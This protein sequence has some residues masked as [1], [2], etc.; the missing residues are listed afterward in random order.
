M[1]AGQTI[2]TGVISGVVGGII[3]VLLVWLIQRFVQMRRL[4]GAL[5]WR[6]PVY[7]SISDL[8]PLRG[9]PRSG[10]K[11][12]YHTRTQD[13]EISDSLIA[14]NHLLIIGDALCGKT[15]A[16]YEAVKKLRLSYRVLLVRDIGPS[17]A[18]GRL[19]WNPLKAL[20]KELVVL[21]DLHRLVALPDFPSLLCRLRERGA[22]LSAT[23]RSGTEG[24]LDI[25]IRAP[26]VYALFG[27]HVHIG[28][29]DRE[30]AQKVAQAAEIP[31]PRHF[32]GPIGSIFLNPDRVLAHL[33]SCTAGEQDILMS[34]AELH[35]AGAGS[36]QDGIPMELVGKACGLTSPAR[37]PKE[38][39]QLVESLAAKGL[40]RANR[41][42]LLC[43][44]TFLERVVAER[45]ELRRTQADIWSCL[46]G[47]PE[48]RQAV[49]LAAIAG[50]DNVRVAQQW[51]DRLLSSGIEPNAGLVAAAVARA[52]TFSLAK[53]WLETM[54][55]SGIK[56]N[57]IAY[58]SL[59]SKASTYDEAVKWFAQMR[60]AGIKPS[61]ISYTIVIERCNTYDE[62]VEWFTEMTNAGIRADVVAFT[63][64]IAM[65]ETLSEA[66]RWFREM[67]RA[68]IIPDVVVYSSLVAKAETYA[69][70]TEWLQKMREAGIAPNVVTYSS[71][72]DKCETY[73]SAIGL[74]K[75]MRNAG[76]T[77]DVVAYTA[78]ISK[79]KTCEDAARWLGEMQGAGIRPDAIAYGSVLVKCNSYDDAKEWLER[80][81]N[82]GVG[83][84]AFMLNNVIAR[85]ESYE[86]AVGWVERMRRERIQPDAF[87][88]NLLVAKC[89]SFEDAIG[90]I[91]RMQGHGVE[92]CFETFTKLFAK[93]LSRVPAKS[94][95]RWFL[96][97]PCHPDRSLQ[98]AIAQYRRRGMISQAFRLT[99]NYPHLEASRRVL[100]ELGEKAIKRCARLLKRDPNHSNATYA[101]GVAFLD[102]GDV[103][104]AAKWLE[105]AADLAFS[106]RRKKVLQEWVAGERG[107]PW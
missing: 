29:I 18:A 2:L 56:P 28:S 34:V 43:E 1:S 22:M 36:S 33:D 95:L 40:L 88:L 104:S 54:R 59:I 71:L 63:S 47:Y 42:K 10:F 100:R 79:S 96:E 57:A 51:F 70:A 87:T 38:W 14:G 19:P 83:I 8:M 16:L 66:L 74:L 76:I 30:T 60:S 35:L 91:G 72:I 103:E 50:T 61:V 90:W 78:L 32:F 81:Q 62:A 106:G 68:G 27:K 39:I 13:K 17:L 92:P 52:P 46:E 85:C 21:D 23:C 9:D 7:L 4:F 75:A 107:Y 97:Q 49:A 44:E 11:D 102:Q 25:K 105:K 3:I 67:Q 89:D 94:L 80:I 101:L 69:D 24:E 77:P 45:N 20:T 41:G 31:L 6:A 84:N 12:Y 15:R 5:F 86:D 48:S 64:L 93:D 99:L 58:G 73:E 65:S 82:E 53:K 55:T 26:D 98:G 37:P